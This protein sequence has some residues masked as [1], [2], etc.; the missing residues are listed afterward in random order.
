MNF[1]LQDLEERSLNTMFDH[2][3][4]ECMRLDLRG[5]VIDMILSIKELRDKTIEEMIDKEEQVV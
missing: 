3:V 2:L 4:I 1:S 5:P